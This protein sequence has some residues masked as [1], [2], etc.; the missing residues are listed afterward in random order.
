LEGFIEVILFTLPILDT[1]AMSFRHDPLIVIGILYLAIKSQT[2][3]RS[4]VVKWWMVIQHLSVECKKYTEYE[5][6]MNISEHESTNVV[7]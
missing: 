1:D 4:R 7:A 3:N 6:V 5:Y 2:V